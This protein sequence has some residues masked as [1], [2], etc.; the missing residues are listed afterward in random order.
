MTKPLMEDRPKHLSRTGFI[1]L[2]IS[3][4]DKEKVDSLKTD[5]QDIKES[6]FLVEVGASGNTIEEAKLATRCLAHLLN[7]LYRD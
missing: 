5:D 4:G 1:H 3:V 7:I 2:C 6:S